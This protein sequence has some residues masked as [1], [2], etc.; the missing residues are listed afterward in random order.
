[1]TKKEATRFGSVQRDEQSVL[2]KL[3]GEFDIRYRST[4]ED[5]LRDCLPPADRR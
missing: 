4:I 2:I 5:T 3:S 1:V